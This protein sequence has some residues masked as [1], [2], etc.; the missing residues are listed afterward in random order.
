MT[1]KDY[2]YNMKLNKT[3]MM[4]A[5]LAASVLAGSTALQAQDA[6]TNSAPKAPPG[7]PMRHNSF[8]MVS[9]Q[10][11]LT[12]DEKPKVQPIWDDM[13][14]QM[15]DLRADTTIAATDKHAKMKDIRDATTAKLKDILT[16]EQLAKWQKIGPGMHRP[17]VATPGTDSS[18]PPAA[19]TT[20]PAGQ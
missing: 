14:K 4:A 2:E 13:Q 9:K 18:T 11:A 20:P 15:R 3:L 16:P 8:D 5:L 7:A 17:P 6:S 19:P 1:P 12:D 10:L